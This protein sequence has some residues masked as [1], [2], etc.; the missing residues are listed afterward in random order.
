MQ[1]ILT[2]SVARG[3]FGGKLNA[4]A[5]LWQT[6]VFSLEKHIVELSAAVAFAVEDALPERVGPDAAYTVRVCFYY[7]ASTFFR[8]ACLVAFT[9]VNSAIFSTLGTM[10]ALTWSS[11]L[12]ISIVTHATGLMVG[13]LIHFVMQKV[14]DESLLVGNGVLRVGP[15]ASLSQE[16]LCSGNVRLERSAGMIFDRLNV[17]IRAKDIDSRCQAISSAFLWC[18]GYPGIILNREF[19]AVDPFSPFE[20]VLQRIGGIV[21]GIVAAVKAQYV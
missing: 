3:G 1:S 13:R 10:P 2:F 21:T 18:R 19:R 15:G 16:E 7:M 4:V 14:I 12:G 20:E 5:A 8:A 11:A 6:R 9:A 17:P